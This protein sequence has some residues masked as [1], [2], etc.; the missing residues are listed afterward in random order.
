MIHP[1]DVVTVKISAKDSVFG[2]L[3]SKADRTEMVTHE[4]VVDQIDYSELD[5]PIGIKVDDFL[6]WCLEEELNVVGKTATKQLLD[7]GGV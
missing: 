1:G 5:L 2:Y 4:Y 7:I 6:I 3:D